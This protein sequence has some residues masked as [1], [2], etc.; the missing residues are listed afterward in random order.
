MDQRYGIVDL[1]DTQIAQ[2]VALEENRENG[3]KIGPQ[4]RKSFAGN[5]IVDNDVLT[6]LDPYFNSII[7]GQTIGSSRANSSAL[8]TRR[9]AHGMSAQAIFTGGRVLDADSSNDN[10]V[11][12][13]ELIED[14]QN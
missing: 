14:V 6:R 9:V 10:G 8:L 13:D 3:G 11:P 7:C 2:G 5:L 1:T 12:N 4:H